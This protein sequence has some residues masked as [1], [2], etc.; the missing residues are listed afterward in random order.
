MCI[1]H[2]QATALRLQQEKVAREKALEEAKW[3]FEHGDAP[4]EEAVKEFNRTERQR[5]AMVET[6]MRREEELQMTQ[7]TG[8][9]KSTAEPRP[10]AYIPD[11]IGIPKPYGNSA[12][13][14]PTELGSSMRHIRL[15]N[16]K[17]IEL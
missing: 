13:F 14:K 12:P 9:Q 4:N 3:R 8:V 16:P 11:D 7:T 15:P 10:T 17:P 1:T 5:L 2:T 6:A